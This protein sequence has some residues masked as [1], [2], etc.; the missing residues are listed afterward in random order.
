MAHS[1]GAGA[2]AVYALVLTERIMSESLHLVGQRR[3]PSAAIGCDCADE[4]KRFS[5]YLQDVIR[6]LAVTIKMWHTLTH[7]CE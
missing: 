1:S 2:S 4:N 5:L 6:P 7:A 3:L